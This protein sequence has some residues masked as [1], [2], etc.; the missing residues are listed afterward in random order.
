MEGNED[1][2]FGQRK[3]IACRIGIVFQN[4]INYR[5][6]VDL[7]VPRKLC[8]TRTRD[9]VRVSSVGGRVDKGHDPCN[10]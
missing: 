5:R 9:D 2:I 6:R 4:C 3:A 8:R 1:D 10:R 7:R